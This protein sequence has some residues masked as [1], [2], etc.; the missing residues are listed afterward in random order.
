MV[1]PGFLSKKCYQMDE[2]QGKVFCKSDG[3]HNGGTDGH[4]EGIDRS[5]GSRFV[6]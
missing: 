1:F 4:K 6:F 5:F 2:L 3:D